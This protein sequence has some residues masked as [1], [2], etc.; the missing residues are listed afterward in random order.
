MHTKTDSQKSDMPIYS[1]VFDPIPVS[2][3]LQLKK[4]IMKI[5]KIKSEVHKDF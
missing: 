4:K 3:Y 2:C 1:A 5:K